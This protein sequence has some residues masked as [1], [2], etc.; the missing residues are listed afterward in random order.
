MQQEPTYY[1]STNNGK[2]PIARDVSAQVY[3]TEEERK[4]RWGKDFSRNE[5]KIS[6]AVEATTGDILLYGDELISAMFFSTSNGKTETAENFSGSDVPYLQS[7][8]SP[9]DSGSCAVRLK[10]E[11][12]IPLNTVERG[13][14]K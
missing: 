8:D 10:Q 4:K 6:A 12:E 5:R 9:G 14:W 7:V 13:I 1:R 2:N 11:T 3:K